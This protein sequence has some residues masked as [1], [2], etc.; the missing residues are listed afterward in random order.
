MTQAE[1][2]LT[3]DFDFTDE[4]LQIDE[5]AGLPEAVQEVAET[6]DKK[7][8]RCDDRVSDYDV[9]WNPK[10]ETVRVAAVVPGASYEVPKEALEDND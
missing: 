1:Q 9:Y 8:V 4:P 5:I 3:A 2:V 6:K 7:L 10:T